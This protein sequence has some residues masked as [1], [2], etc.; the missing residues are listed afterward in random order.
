MTKVL[1]SAQQPSMFAPAEDWEKFIALMDKYAADGDKNAATWARI[2][3]ER[4]KEINAS[5]DQRPTG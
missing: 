5:N 2:G 4:L 3:R 1:L